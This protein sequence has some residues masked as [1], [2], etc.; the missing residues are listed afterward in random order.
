[1][2]LASIVLLIYLVFGHSEISF[3]IGY[4][5]PRVKI[6][7]E[8]LLVG[9]SAF[10]RVGAMS[11]M[12]AI[13]N[14]TLGHYGGDIG[15]ATFAVIF[16][17]LSFIFMPIIGL[18]MGLQPIVGFNFGAHQFHRVRQSIKLTIVISSIAAAMGFLVV[19]VFPEAIMKIFTRD[20]KLVSYGKDALRLCM[21]FLPLAGAQAVGSAF[22]QALGKVVPAILL[23]LSRQVL[24]LIPLIILLPRFLGISGVWISFPVADLVSFIITMIL[25]WAE[26]KKMPKDVPTTFPGAVLEPSA[27]GMNQG[28]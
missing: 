28:L 8:M 5:R 17:L 6:V 23:S 15:I 18:S 27:S 19:L 22:F 16:R 25:V 24:A 1:M 21:I 26:L 7:K 4:L 12:V 3:K 2:A 14:H 9:S 13:L 11:L 20:P 10:V